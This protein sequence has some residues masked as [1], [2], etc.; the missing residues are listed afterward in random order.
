M[1]LRLSVEVKANTDP[2]HAPHRL[3]TMI[4]V[5]GNVS[6]WYCD[7]LRL[8]NIND[9][10]MLGTRDR[11]NGCG[12]WRHRI[13]ALCH[14]W[15]ELSAGSFALSLREECFRS[16]FLLHVSY[17]TRVFSL[18]WE[19]LQSC[20]IHHSYSL[21][22]SHKCLVLFWHFSWITEAYFMTLFAT[23]KKKKS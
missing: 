18:Q 13:P 11:W 16:A 1:S 2:E 10:S 15:R 5:K 14:G 12:C 22:E 7:L 3:L 17:M 4:V 6:D 19:I 21:G 23:I 20:E 9:R 8:C